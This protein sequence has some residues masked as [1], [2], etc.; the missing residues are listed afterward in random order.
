MMIIL[1]QSEHCIVSI[2]ANLVTKGVFFHHFIDTTNNVIDDRSK[3]FNAE[4]FFGFR[5]IAEVT[6][7]HRK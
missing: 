1:E 7:K 4:G 3:T 2:F 5:R 6:S